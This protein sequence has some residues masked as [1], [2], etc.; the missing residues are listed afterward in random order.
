MATLKQI[1][2]KADAKLAIFWAALQDKQNAYFDKRGKYFQLLVSP[3]SLVIDG[4]D[5][6]YINRVPNDELYIIDR[7]FSFAEKTPFQ[8]E[9]NEW[10]SLLEAGY[11]ATVYVKLLDGR[12]FTRTRQHTNEDTGWQEYLGSD[13][14]V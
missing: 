8:I 9:V 6:D 4:L 12:I 5:S 11:S 13:I 14:N 3:T 7:E 2:D 10:R 1:R